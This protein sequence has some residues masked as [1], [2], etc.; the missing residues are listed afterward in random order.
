MKLAKSPGWLVD[1]FDALQPGVGGERKQ[2]FGYPCAFENG[3]LFTGL[4]ADGLFVRLGEA[5]RARLLAT[6]GAAPFEPME[7]R[8]M[9]EY[10]VL[11][12]SMLED[13]EAVK[14]WMRL[15]LDYAR[16]LPGK[17]KKGAAKKK[18]SPSTKTRGKR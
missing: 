3:N 10:V 14:S 8:Q 2:M 17:E 15:G 7:G 16:S 9:R 4:F 1:L 5:D 18:P 12:A 11:P 6:K 13:E